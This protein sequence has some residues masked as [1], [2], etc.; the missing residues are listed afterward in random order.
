LYKLY[1]AGIASYKRT[2][3]PDSN[4]EIY[5]W[6]FDQKKVSEI[7]SEKYEKLSRDIEKSIKYEEEN[8]FFV[9]KINGHRYKFEN[10]SVNN[11]V[12]P[13]CGESLEYQDN[14]EIIVKL[15]RDKERCIS[16]EN[17]SNHDRF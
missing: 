9:C 6:K 5:N 15:I 14:S 11:F 4:W 12:C 8:M 10:A 3:N 16:R 13:Q 2:K 1:D 7:I 17:L